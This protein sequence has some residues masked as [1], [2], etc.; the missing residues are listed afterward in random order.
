MDKFPHH[1]DR[2]VPGF[3]FLGY[4]RFLHLS[5]YLSLLN[6]IDTFWGVRPVVYWVRAWTVVRQIAVRIP[7]TALFIISR[8][9]AKRN[10]NITRGIPLAPT[11]II[12]R[13]WKIQG[14]KI[15]LNGDWP[16]F[17]DRS[18]PTLMWPQL[19]KKKDNP[20]CMNTNGSLC[21][22]RMT[23]WFNQMQMASIWRD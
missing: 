7:V 4:E 15:L 8:P 16:S 13:G 11:K 9:T 12:S 18:P 19:K 14:V 5:K 21:L 20:W 2:Y 17:L 22:D 6:Y 3:S 1:T 23:N 10:N